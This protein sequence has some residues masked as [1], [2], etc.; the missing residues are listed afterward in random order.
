MALNTQALI[1]YI[2]C[3][4]GGKRKG[5]NR[6][7]YAS[8]PEL[9]KIHDEMK[10]LRDR[11]IAH[12]AGPH[13]HLEL[14]VAAE[15]PDDAALGIGIYSFFLSADNPASLRNFLRLI[16]FAD[17][18]VYGE[19]ERIGNVMAKD[20]MG[21]KATWKNSI[22]KFYEHIDMSQI[23]RPMKV[24]PPESLTRRSVEMGAK[25]RKPDKN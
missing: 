3:F 25:P 18:Y 4:G 23:Y 10:H 6:E 20:L 21:P 22:R 13:E 24:V 1:S 5:L 2:R 7:V 19:I 15:S 8:K 14:L 11:H 9:Q 17:K 12:S 16:K